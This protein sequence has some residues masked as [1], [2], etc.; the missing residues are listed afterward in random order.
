[1]NKKD[2]E[3]PIVKFCKF[4]IISVIIAALLSSSEMWYNTFIIGRYYEHSTF[5]GTAI[6]GFIVPVAS[7]Y[8]T[9]LIIK[10]IIKW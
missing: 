9:Y 10:S 1:M 3:E 6:V 7:I 2:K 8:F 5:L 4:L